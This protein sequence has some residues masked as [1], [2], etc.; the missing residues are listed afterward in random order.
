M[1]QSKTIFIDNEKI[2]IDKEDEHYL[3]NKAYDRK[4]R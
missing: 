1:M 2:I 3:H 4:I